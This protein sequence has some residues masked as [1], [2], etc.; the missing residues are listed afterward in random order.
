MLT[1]A[2]GDAGIDDVE[3]GSAGADREHDPRSEIRGGVVHTGGSSRALD[4]TRDTWIAS[5][6]DPGVVSRGAGRRGECP[7]D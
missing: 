4:I 2:T 6:A 5:I 7:R 1:V 3:V